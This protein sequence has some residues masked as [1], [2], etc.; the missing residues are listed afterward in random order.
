[1]DVAVS[2]SL[3]DLMQNTTKILFYFSIGL[4]LNK[5]VPM[6]LMCFLASS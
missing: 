4:S 1:M 6:A 5:K 2:F 3:E